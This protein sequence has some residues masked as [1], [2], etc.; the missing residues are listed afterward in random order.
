MTK[1]EKY[2][3]INDSLNVFSNNKGKF[4]EKLKNQ[5]FEV[6]K[7]NDK[8]KIRDFVNKPQNGNK[9]S[10][11]E[12]LCY[13]EDIDTLKMTIEYAECDKNNG[14]CN[15]L[16]TMIGYY[17]EDDYEFF[18]S[19]SK[20]R[21]GFF[22]KKTCIEDTKK[23]LDYFE[24]ST[25]NEEV[26]L[27]N[28]VMDD[29]IDTINRIVD[30]NPKLLKSRY[31]LDDTLLMVATRNGS[32]KAAIA[33]ID[34]G[35]NIMVGNH[36]SETPLALAAK[37][38]C[39]DVV[40]K[41][42]SKG[43][44]VNS[45]L[46]QT[47]LACAAENGHLEIVKTLMKYGANLELNE[48]YE[49]EK[50]EKSYTQIFTYTE[51]TPLRLAVK[52]GYVDIVDILLK[53]GAKHNFDELLNLA[54][55]NGHTNVINE[56]IKFKNNENINNNTI[57]LA[58]LISAA[59]NNDIN[60]INEL[61]NFNPNII[62]LQDQEG[63]T[64]FMYAAEKGHLNIIN[65]LIE[66]NPDII[67][68]QDKN[69]KTALIYAIENNNIDIINKLIEINPDIIN[70]QDKN[71]KTPL[72]YAIENDN[73]DIVN[74]MIKINR[75]IVNL[76][77]SSGKT[78]L[79]Y[80]AENSN[81]EFTKVLIEANANIN[82]T[83]ENGN[84]ALAYAARKHGRLENIKFLINHNINKNLI[85][86]YLLLYAA[87]TNNLET[88]KFLVD[89]YNFNLT[90]DI[91]FRYSNENPFMHSITFQETHCSESS[92]KK[93]KYP[94]GCEVFDFFLKK[95]KDVNFKNWLGETLLMRAIKSHNFMIF[96]KL[97]ELG[98]NIN[99]LNIFN[100]NALSTAINCNIDV[101][102][103][104]D[105]RFFNALIKH[106]I[107]VTVRDNNGETNL[108]NVIEIKY[109]PKD[110]RITIVN[111]LLSVNNNVNVLD[112]KGHSALFYAVRNCLFDVA[113]ILIEAGADINIID[114]NGYNILMN[115]ISE[116]TSRKRLDMGI[117][118]LNNHNF[119]ANINIPAAY[120]ALV[121]ATLKDDSKIIKFLKDKGFEFN[122]ALNNADFD[123]EQF[124]ETIHDSLSKKGLLINIDDISNT[125]RDLVIKAV[126]IAM[127][128][129]GEG[130]ISPFHGKN[131]PL[132]DFIDF[133]ISVMQSNF[134][135]EENQKLN[136]V[137]VKFDNAAINRNQEEINSSI[138]DLFELC[139]T[140]ENIFNVVDSIIDRNIVKQNTKKNIIEPDTYNSLTKLLNFYG[141]NTEE[142]SKKI[143]GF[144]KVFLK[145][146]IE[147]DL[148]KRQFNI[149]DKIVI[150]NENNTNTEL[151]KSIVNK[152]FGVINKITFDE[153]FDTLSQNLNINN[154]CLIYQQNKTEEN[155]QN[156]INI[157][158]NNTNDNQKDTLLRLF[159]DSSYLFRVGRNEEMYSFMFLFNFATDSDLGTCLKEKLSLCNLANINQELNNTQNQI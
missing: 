99:A 67:N 19:D 65:R 17:Y 63:K 9:M 15:V 137:I 157:I 60:T 38:G 143:E 2:Y 34:A 130:I 148:F 145:Q 144:S 44:N 153:D 90:E 61:L 135:E 136:N 100:R 42:I 6:L 97:I 87:E 102:S 73:I 152:F 121:Y 101:M 88:A 75:D 150:H 68:L 8:E 105:T 139:K 125:K 142:F 31:G 32:S 113:E 146:N 74:K 81:I 18:L 41:I 98:A 1:Y 158:I 16:N 76:E 28:A 133:G 147:E 72:M 29:D 109:I 36:E 71:K 82:A 56:L 4:M 13:I 26:E 43:V 106:G 59:V 154:A 96:N 49:S 5:F 39:L 37:N 21:T 131:T 80:A 12:Y 140:Y 94:Y 35:A 114:Q 134:T 116:T 48:K 64:A 104:P 159:N 107:D 118:F 85:N 10:F 50:F 25:T 57:Q 69:G 111:T 78:S 122:N 108:M 30:S 55:T 156:L 141:F 45:N 27:I 151:D 110:T 14:F 7:S 138:N 89:K 91:P 155:K 40:N 66:F 11:I 117:E 123:N 92:S 52:N 86:P 83:D 23:N 120:N 33:L 24:K 119:T 22:T 47:A 128:D 70:L 103:F 95:C 51:E 79:M 124:K 20:C 58:Y 115:L 126:N 93:L 132:K 127:H 62:N 77:N 129:F 46:C 54:A 112:K 149:T 84:S 3:T 53:A